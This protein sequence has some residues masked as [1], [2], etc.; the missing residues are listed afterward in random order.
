MSALL[1]IKGLRLGYGRADVV[2][3]VDLVV[4]RVNAQ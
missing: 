1:E 4:E 2:K 3:G